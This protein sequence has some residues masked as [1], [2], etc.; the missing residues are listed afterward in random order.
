MKFPAHATLCAGLGGTEWWVPGQQSDVLAATKL[1]G[2]FAGSC[3][4]KF[5]VPVRKKN[6]RSETKRPNKPHRN[7]YL[8]PADGW[9]C[10]PPRLST[11][12]GTRASPTE[13]TTRTVSRPRLTHRNI[14][15]RHTN[16]PN[17]INIIYDTEK[18]KHWVN[19]YI[20]S[21]PAAVRYVKLPLEASALRHNC[22]HPIC[23]LQRWTYQSVSQREFRELHFQLNDL[24]ILRHGPSDIIWLISFYHKMSGWNLCLCVL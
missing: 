7:H 5:W 11:S 20:Y 24:Q 3:T 6:G 17:F 2:D 18:S 9:A 8:S 16:D 13:A 12:P 15:E 1:F 10:P 4:S 22:S 21:L 14:Q 23:R 19:I